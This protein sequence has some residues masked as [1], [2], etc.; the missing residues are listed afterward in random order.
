V[1]I[2]ADVP[3][4][5]FG[6]TML[7]EGIGDILN[8]VPDIPK[9]W[10]LI[11]VPKI[12]VSTKWVYEKYDTLSATGYSSSARPD[13][14]L[15]LK[16]L[17]E[18]DIK[19]LAKNMKNVLEEVTVREYPVIDVIKKRMIEYGALGSVMSGSGPSVFGIFDDYKKGVFCKNRFLDEGKYRV[20]Y[21]Y[22]K[23]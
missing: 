6:K 10:I 16:A 17:K 3:Y 19:L 13:I 14:N 12:R 4:C 15:L 9:C 22:Y 8:E 7:A 20:I 21:T 5:I 1:K 2:G 23:N 11:V 18:H